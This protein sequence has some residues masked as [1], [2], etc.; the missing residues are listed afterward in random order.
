MDIES[1]V[2]EELIFSSGTLIP[3]SFVDPL[4]LSPSNPLVDWARYTL[5][6]AISLLGTSDMVQK[7]EI[8][9]DHKQIIKK[10]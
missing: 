1:A 9:M 6:A 4:S 8:N 5:L 10:W 7:S 2:S 3:F